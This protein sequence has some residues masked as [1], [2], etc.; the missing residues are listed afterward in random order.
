MNLLIVGLIFFSSFQAYSGQHRG[1][2]DGIENDGNWSL[3]DLVEQYEANYYFPQTEKY[4]ASHVADRVGFVANRCAFPMTYFMQLQKTFVDKIREINRA[5]ADSSPYDV[6]LIFPD[7]RSTHQF[8]LNRSL[9]YPYQ[10]SEFQTIVDVKTGAR[11]SAQEIIW[12]M[13]DKELEEI[14]DE[15]TI[16]LPAENESKKQLAIQKDGVVLIHRPIFEK[17]DDRNKAALIVHELMLF[18]AMHGGSSNLLQNGTA[19]VRRI[20]H[21][22]FSESYFEMPETVF[23]P[24]CAWKGSAFQDLQFS[25]TRDEKV[26]VGSGHFRIFIG[27]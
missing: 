16:R 21:A 27:R 12:M 17:M 1:G 19:E 10:Q 18:A 11:L 2:G 22:L 14:P 9:P 3:L 5:K 20:V 15:G 6:R 25:V 26:P 8:P 4:F 24:F 13:T 7:P 23:G